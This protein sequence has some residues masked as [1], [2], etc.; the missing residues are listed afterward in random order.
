MHY[1]TFYPLG[2][3]DTTLIQLNNGKNILFDYMHVKSAEED[4]DKRCDLKKELNNAVTADSFDVVCFTHLDEDHVRGAHDFFHLDYAEKYQGEGRKKITEMWVPAEAITEPKDSCNESARVVQAEARHR[5]KN[6]YG[7]KVFSRPKK[8]KEWCDKNEGYDYEK[9]KDRIVDAGKLVDPEALTNDGAEFFSHCPFYSESKDIDRNNKGIVVQCKFDN[10]HNST[11]ILGADI[12]YKV[13]ENIISVTK[14][15]DNEARLEWDLFHISHHCSYKAL[16]EEKGE[17][18]TS[19]SDNIRWLYEEQGDSTGVIISPSNPIPKKYGPKKKE[20]P[21][22]KQAY[23][24]YDEDASGT[25]KVTMQEPS[26]E[27]P[28]PLKY[29]IGP[30]GVRRYSALAAVNIGT[31]RPSSR[32]LRAGSI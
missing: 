13:W 31:S 5:L 21:P 15:N 28:K 26:P 20:Q 4:E 23:N 16:A 19:P 1:V 12:D 32:P 30:N 14:A 29:E 7:I 18:K 6:N 24:Y 2:N 22:H 11:L 25:V 9:I 27:N 17:E 8:F 3:A 10:S